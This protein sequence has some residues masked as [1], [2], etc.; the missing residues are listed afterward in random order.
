[1]PERLGGL[2]AALALPLQD[3]ELFLVGELTLELLLR[4]TQARQDQAQRVTPIGVA[5]QR[6]CLQL[7]FHPDDQAHAGSPW[8]R[9]PRMCQ[10]RWKIVCPPPSPTVTTTR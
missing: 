10:W 4:R 3:L 9:P 8:T 2:E 6:C 7:L 5:R 1:A